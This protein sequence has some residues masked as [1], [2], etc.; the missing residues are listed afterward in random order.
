M[1]GSGD[2]RAG[3]PS[4]WIDKFG[5]RVS[6]DF[7]VTCEQKTESC[8][9]DVEHF[10]SRRSKKFGDAS[11]DRVGLLNGMACNYSWITIY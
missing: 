11:P 8:T 4:G 3:L 7:S 2:Y 5:S 6:L 9:G 1:V 10:A